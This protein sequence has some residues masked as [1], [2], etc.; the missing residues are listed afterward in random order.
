ML[1]PARMPASPTGSVWAMG[2]EPL[3]V[4]IVDDEPDVMLLLR[5]QLEG[6]PDVAVVGTASDGQEAIEQCHAL[7]PDAVI[8]DLL[9][10]RMN[11]FQ[12]IEA[13]ARDLPDIGLVAYSA[14]AG[15]HVRDE[16]DK[17]G[18]PLLLKSGEVGPLVEALQ[19]A[20]VKAGRK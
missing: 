20:A 17:L 2:S 13:L 6:R 4:L 14:V 8:M 7:Q 19:Q 3:R 11:G 5:V 12:A 10:P 1:R 16:M 9:M 18:V 15:E